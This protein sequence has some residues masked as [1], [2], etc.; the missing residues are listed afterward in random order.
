MVVP[1]AR[2]AVVVTNRNGLHH[3]EECFDS[4]QRQTFRDFSIVFVDNA[5]TDGSVEWVTEHRPDARVIVH[6]VDTGWSTSANDGI[7]TAEGDYVVTLNND[8][9]L[10]PTWLEALV[11]AMDLNPEYDFG[12]S[13][14]IMYFEPNLTNAAGDGYSVKSVCG[15]NRGWRQPVSGFDQPKRVLGACAG[16][17]IYRR[18]FFDDVGFFDEDFYLVHEDTDLNLRALIAGKRC[19]YV[20]DARVFH[21][22]R[23][24]ANQFAAGYLDRLDTRNRM[25]VAAKD[26]PLVLLGYC[27]RNLVWPVLR[28]TL[29]LRPS[30]WR[31]VPSLIESLPERFPEVEGVRMGWAKRKNVWS[32]R[33]VGR[34]T[35]F[36]WIFNGVSDV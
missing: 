10:E 3:L 14:M 23:S 2:V 17:A 4:L 34:L 11:R 9:R 16:A 22:H 1:P 25:F 29:P 6:D 7:K 13:L 12:A 15:V 36:R 5:S 24:S 32:K 30:K 8:V 26:L 35:I 27:L 20:P 19:L 31:L 21:K 28:S 33:Q 18:G